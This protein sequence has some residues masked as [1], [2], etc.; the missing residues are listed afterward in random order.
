MTA[1]V[2][3]FPT[4]TRTRRSE[5]WRP[6]RGAYNPPLEPMPVERLPV[7]VAACRVMRLTFAFYG[8]AWLAWLALR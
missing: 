3:Q 4:P 6:I 2:I 8:T 7:T 5:K 1:T